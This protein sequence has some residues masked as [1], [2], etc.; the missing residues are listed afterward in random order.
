MEHRA[1]IVQQRV[2]RHPVPVVPQ[3]ESGADESRTRPER[4]GDHVCGLLCS[5]REEIE[6]IKRGV[7]LSLVL[8]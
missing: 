1:D 4:E 3:H 7:E 2:Q 5:A 8:R 6:D